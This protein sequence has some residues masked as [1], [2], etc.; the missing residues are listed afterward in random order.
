MNIGKYAELFSNEMS[1][2]N[3]SYNTIKSYKNCLQTFLT[4]ASE[5]YDQPKDISEEAIKK[6]LLWVQRKSSVAYQ[7]QMTSAIKLFYAKIIKQPNKLQNTQYPK[8]EQKL[9]EILS[10]QEIKRLF[11]A[12]NVNLKHQAIIAL[13]YSCGLRV[14][15]IINLKLSDVDS[16]RM[17]IRVL[18]GKG[19]KD[20]Q[21][22]LDASVLDLLR[23]YF[24]QYR[25][26]EYLFNGQGGLPQYS[27]TSI[28]QFLNRY[29]E[30]A[31]IKKHV[32]PH[33]LRH[34]FAVHHLEQGTDLRYIQVFLGH[35][36][37]KTTERYTHVSNLNLNLIK[38]PIY[39]MI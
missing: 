18:Q 13:L 16:S 5:K 27:A 34:C 23:R 19:K 33:Q 24:M 14:S 20:R 12:S 3:F 39:G 26:K 36:N 25:P 32:H 29:A 8:P 22:S 9:P 10:K 21:V 17:V 1:M 30:K 7:R 2:L 38:S 11:S 28:R 37:V 35:S 15:E 4:L 31:G 6:F